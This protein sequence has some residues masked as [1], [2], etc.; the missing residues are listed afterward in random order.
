MLL[1]GF[2]SSCSCHLRKSLKGR[3][4]PFVSPMIHEPSPISSLLLLHIL[5]V[6]GV[7][8]AV[9]CGLSGSESYS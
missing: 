5:K 6:Q 4:F 8:T 7:D 9:K 2:T 3:L 1:A